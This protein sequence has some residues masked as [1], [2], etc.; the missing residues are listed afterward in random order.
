MVLQTNPPPAE[1][2]K[3][4]EIQY[5]LGVE[6][7]AELLPTQKVE[8]QFLAGQLRFRPPLEELRLNFDREVRSREGMGGPP[9]FVLPADGVHAGKAV[10]PL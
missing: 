4:L 9:N 6:S 3:A 7:M 1:V 5:L 8:V 2:C 10:G